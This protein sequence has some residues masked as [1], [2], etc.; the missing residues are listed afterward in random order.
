MKQSIIPGPCQLSHILSKNHTHRCSQAIVLRCFSLAGTC[1][2][3]LFPLQT[4][5][6]QGTSSSHTTS[7]VG[8]REGKDDSGPLHPFSTA[9]NVSC[10][11]HNECFITWKEWWF[12]H[13]STLLSNARV[14]CTYFSFRGLHLLL[15]LGGTGLCL[16][17][18]VINSDIECYHLILAIAALDLKAYSSTKAEGPVYGRTTVAAILVPLEGGPTWRLPGMVFV[19]TVKLHFSIYPFLVS[20]LMSVFS[21]HD[22]WPRHLLSPANVVDNWREA[23]EALGVL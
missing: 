15:P 23:L 20:S 11:L 13:N 12:E 10:S 22:I 18:D 1:F 19:L 5:F 21:G 6:Q 2:P 3:G 4:P 7:M 16:P 17:Y 14:G 9:F 8:G